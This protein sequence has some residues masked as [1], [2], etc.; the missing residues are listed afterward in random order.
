MQTQATLLKRYKEVYPK[1]TFQV[2]SKKTNIQITRVFRIFN[3]SE[4]KL[5]EYLSI[6]ELL[7]SKIDSKQFIQS[8]KSCLENL[9]IDKVESLMNQMNH[10]LKIASLRLN[11]DSQILVNQ[12]HA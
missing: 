2:I 5:K 3:G 8:A 7:Q 9:S 10:S 11:S 6:N 1:D 12:L 4:M